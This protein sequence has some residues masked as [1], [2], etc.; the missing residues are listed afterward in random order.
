MCFPLYRK[1]FTNYNALP[2]Y[3]S[4]PLVAQARSLVHHST[5]SSSPL[6]RPP[7]DQARSW[8]ASSPLFHSPAGGD[9]KQDTSFFAI[10]YVGMLYVSTF[11]APR[12][13][14]CVNQGQ[15]W[16]NIIS[17][18]SSFQIIFR[19]RWMEEA[20]KPSQSC[21]VS[22]TYCIIYSCSIYC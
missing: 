1:Y 17:S 10:R 15:P 3:V 11:P 20:R 19:I 22:R 2:Q 21:S 16:S 13:T 7:S 5:V 14:V 9:K 4:T 6:D 12:T 8:C 18:W